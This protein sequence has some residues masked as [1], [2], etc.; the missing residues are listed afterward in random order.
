MNHILIPSNS[1]ALLSLLA[2]LD[3]CTLLHSSHPNSLS[4]ALELDLIRAST[5]KE[6]PVICMTSG[7][8]KINLIS[9]KYIFIYKGQ[10]RK[11][12]CNRQG[13]TEIR[14]RL[15]KRIVTEIRVEMRCVIFFERWHYIW[16]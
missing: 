10:P 3:L 4:Q 5:K 2:S 1:F 12:Q 13:D 9:H 6:R 14:T 8:P 16:Y 11:T 15:C 7:L